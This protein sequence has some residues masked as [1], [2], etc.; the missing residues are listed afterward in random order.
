MKDTSLP[1]KVASNTN[2]FRKAMKSLGFNISVSCYNFQ[3]NELNVIFISK[4]DNHAISPVMLGDAKLASTFADMM[5]SL[6]VFH[7]K[8]NK[9]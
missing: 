4:G 3:G 2:R 9:N 7:F 6:F 1:Q 8:P 5:L